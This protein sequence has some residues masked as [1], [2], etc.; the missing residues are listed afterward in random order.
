MGGQ[1]FSRV[2][3]LRANLFRLYFLCLLCMY[4]SF[5]RF[6]FLLCRLVLFV[7]CSW[8]LC[9]QSCGLLL[10]VMLCRL[11]LGIL[12]C[13]R[14][15]LRLYFFVLHCIRLCLLSFLVLVVC[16]G[17]ARFQILIFRLDRNRL[18]ISSSILAGLFLFILISAHW[19]VPMQI[20]SPV[21]SSYISK[22]RHEVAFSNLLAQVFTFIFVFQHGRFFIWT[23]Q[24]SMT[25]V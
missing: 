22:S 18:C 20:S 23:F 11:F 17:F 5:L 15:R 24:Y 7:F 2:L 1:F 10:L 4:Y 13:L 8:F 16:L 19:L 3:L 9:F 21:S 6:L 25:H 12:R 14:G